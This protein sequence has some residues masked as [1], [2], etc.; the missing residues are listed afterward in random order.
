MAHPAV[1]KARLAHIEDK[2]LHRL[3][4]VADE[5]ALDDVACLERGE[6]VILGPAAGAHFAADI[7]NAASG[8]GQKLRILILEIDV[9]DAVKIVA[10]DIDRQLAPPILLDALPHDL[11]SREEAGDAV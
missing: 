4:A 5:L 6:I 2:G 3:H 1:G 7:L 11:R 8:E 9:A 10:P